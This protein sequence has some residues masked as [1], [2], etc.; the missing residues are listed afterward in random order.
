MVQTTIVMRPQDRDSNEALMGTDY[1][2][3]TQQKHACVTIG[4][5]ITLFEY[6]AGGMIG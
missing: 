4:S 5:E 6:S 1:V 2:K 3:Y